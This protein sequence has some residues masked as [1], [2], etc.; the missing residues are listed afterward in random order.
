MNKKILI[1]SF[2][3]VIIL[4]LVSFTSVVGFHTVISTSAK[5]SPLFSIRAKRAIN[6][7]Q[8]ALTCDYVGKGEESVL[9]IPKRDDRTA[10]VQNFIDRV[11]KMDDKTF[12]RYQ[13]LIINQIQKNDK[14]DDVNINEV[15]T[16]IR[17]L[18]DNPER[19][20][21]NVNKNGNYTWRDKFTPTIC[22]VPFCFFFRIIDIIESIYLTIAIVFFTFYLIF[23]NTTDP[24][25]CLTYYCVKSDF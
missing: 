22:W 18:R 15:I 2:V 13:N 11:S 12:K 24:P 5:D 9:S 23:I 3:A 21:L 10:L 17:Q 16:A 4:I 25:N 6:K 14:Y 19:I 7:E 20:N 1:G 8:D